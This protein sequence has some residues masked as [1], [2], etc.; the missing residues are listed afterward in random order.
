MR[1]VLLLGVKQVLQ[2]DQFTFIRPKHIDEL[3]GTVRKRAAVEDALGRTC[4][5]RD[6][7][8]NI[9]QGA[10]TIRVSCR[11]RSP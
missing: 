8:H 6:V 11:K 5:L 2:L 7:L 1:V 10:S 9:E 3:V 4:R